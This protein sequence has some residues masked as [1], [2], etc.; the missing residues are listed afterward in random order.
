MLLVTDKERNIDR[1][2]IRRETKSSRREQKRKKKK[3]EN[4]PTHTPAGLHTTHNGYTTTP[5]PP[6]MKSA[7]R[8]NAGPQTSHPKPN[9]SNPYTTALLPF[10]TLTTL[11]ISPSLNKNTV[12]SFFFCCSSVMY[13]LNGWVKLA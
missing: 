1:V 2:R 12:H 8:E 3:K 4:S 13:L 11:R 6:P 9:K 10:Q 7:G 5:S